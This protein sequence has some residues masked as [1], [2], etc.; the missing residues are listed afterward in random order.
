MN[1]PLVGVNLCRGNSGSLEILPGSSNDNRM[2]S[3][4]GFEICETRLLLQSMLPCLVHSSERQ[5]T[6]KN[7]AWRIDYECHDAASTC[8][9][10][11]TAVC[12]Q[13]DVLQS[14]IAVR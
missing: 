7:L 1:P 5:A 6:G 2:H 11:V 10:T 8:R 3:I 9:L 12:I 13:S 14:I 4:D